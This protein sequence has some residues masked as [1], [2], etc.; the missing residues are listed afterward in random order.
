MKQRV[1]SEVLSFHGHSTDLY[2]LKDTLTFPVI[3]DNVTQ[4]EQHECG[5]IAEKILESVIHIT[6]TA[7]FYD[8]KIPS[9]ADG[10]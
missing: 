1:H 10:Q 9:D 5:V 8:G 4:V 7:G 6:Q 3:E 2:I